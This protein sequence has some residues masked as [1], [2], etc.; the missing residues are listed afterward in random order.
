MNNKPEVLK[1]E[2]WPIEKLRPNSW[3]PNLMDE[4]VYE[5]TKLSIIEEGFSDPIDI[6][7]T[8]LILDGEHRYKA[9]LDLGLTEIPVFVKE[10]YNDDAVI[11]TIRKDRTHGEPDLVKLSEIV[12]DL[13]DEL[14][15]NEVERRLGYDETEQQAFLEV[16][17]WDWASYGTDDAEEDFAAREDDVTWSVGMDPSVRE[18]LEAVLPSYG[19][20]ADQTKYGDTD[21]GRFV[22]F[23]ADAKAKGG[24]T[25]DIVDE[26]LIETA[27]EDLDDE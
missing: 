24:F 4:K 15:T 19:L 6:D 1:S 2:M 22:A 21:L 26:D 12:G 3:N 18:R 8:G 7:P 27:D 13:V 9:A 25:D 5:L 11:T 23:V 17:R 14:G 20:I 16:T 10:R